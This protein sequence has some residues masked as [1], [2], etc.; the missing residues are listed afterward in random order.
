MVS[1]VMRRF[2]QNFLA[3]IV[4][5]AL[6]FIMTRLS[7]D[8]A[9]LYLSEDATA[10]Q[11]EAYTRALGLD[12]SLPAQF[13][14]YL[15]QLLHFDFGSSLSRHVPAIDV[16]LERYPV[17]LELALVTMTVTI[18]LAVLVGGL[19]AWKPTSRMDHVVTSLSLTASA[20]PDFWLGIMGITIFGVWL[21][22]LPLGG[23]GGDWRVWVLPVLTLMARPFGILVQVV[24]GAMINTLHS[25]YITTARAKGATEGRVLFIHALRNAALPVITVA[26]LQLTSDRQWCGW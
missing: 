7:G 11:R 6:V 17:T 26:G 5:L 9:S 1:S 16:V 12:Q 19:A 22:M 25:K 24:R 20:T 13:M 15:N 18:V 8:P 23:Y 14:S 2:L 3:L 10:Q 4:L 21:G